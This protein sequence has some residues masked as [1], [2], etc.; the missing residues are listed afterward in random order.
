MSNTSKHLALWWQKLLL[1]G[2]L[3]AIFLLATGQEEPAATADCCMEDEEEEYII[4]DP[5]AATLKLNGSRVFAMRLKSGRT[6]IKYTP[7]ERSDLLRNVNAL[8][9]SLHVFAASEA[10]LSAEAKNEYEAGVILHQLD[11]LEFAASKVWDDF[12]AFAFS[13]QPGS[14]PRRPIDLLTISPTDAPV[15]VE[16]VREDYTSWRGTVS[17]TID[18]YEFLPGG[19]Q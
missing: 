12:L 18:P 17:I 15:S 16:A 6:V 19:I 2:G 7:S 4:F 11:P 9:D 10:E 3:G 1:I 5:P 8:S 14:L 13:L